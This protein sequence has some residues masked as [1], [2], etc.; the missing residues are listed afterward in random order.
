MYL[1]CV[2][3][4]VGSVAANLGAA[5]NAANVTV[6]KCCPY[7]ETLDPD[8][9][10]KPACQRTVD[11]K[12][13]RWPPPVYS[14]RRHN[15]LPANTTPSN[16]IVHPASRPA[17]GDRVSMVRV[18]PQGHPVFVMFEEGT[19]FLSENEKFVEPGRFCV[20]S[21]A[22]LVCSDDDAQAGQPPSNAIA[23]GESVMKKKPKKL[24]IRKCCGSDAVYSEE[25]S[26][27]VPLAEPALDDHF[28]DYLDEPVRN[29]FSPANGFP[30]CRK[31]GYVVRGQLGGSLKM[32]TDGT[33]TGKDYR[34]PLTSSEYCL[35]VVRELGERPAVLSCPSEESMDDDSRGVAGSYETDVRFTVYPALLFLSVFFLAATLLALCLVPAVHQQVHWRCQTNYVGSLMFGDLLLAIT[36]VSGDALIHGPFCIVFGE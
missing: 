3:L 34:K 16:W 18:H 10:D 25:K 12:A 24:R 22:A 4:F 19:L 7:G 26:G 15:L 21:T 5:P 31:P 29:Q 23:V 32:E 1:L 8:T 35:E 27:C 9:A 6:L 13:A 11:E 20:D 14:R 33:I 28:W 2:L 36:Q 17:C 30:A